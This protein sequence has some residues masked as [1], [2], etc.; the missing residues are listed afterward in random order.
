MTLLSMY[1][2]DDSRTVYRILAQQAVHYFDHPRAGG[3]SKILFTNLARLL[4]RYRYDAFSHDVSPGILEVF[5]TDR[6]PQRAD[7]NAAAEK[8]SLDVMPALE[9]AHA[10]VYRA[11]SREDLVELLKRLLTQLAVSTPL[12]EEG[13][14]DEEIGRARLFFATLSERL[15]ER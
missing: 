9:A 8:T 14:N 11:L 1:K 12:G 15:K 7:W 3:E 10:S 4:E 13:R 6:D 2:R 5:K